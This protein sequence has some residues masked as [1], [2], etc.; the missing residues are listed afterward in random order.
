M[1]L[2]FHSHSCDILVEGDLFGKGIKLLLL[3][4]LVGP[5]ICMV[6]FLCVWNK[7]RERLL[8]SQ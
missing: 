1:V 6:L 8:A 4:L 2:A 7:W 3:L 5:I